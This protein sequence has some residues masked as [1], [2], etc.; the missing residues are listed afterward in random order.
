MKIKITADSTADL[1]PELYKAYDIDCLPLYLV[2]GGEPFKDGLE[3]TPDDI[4]AH[5]DGGGQI[6]STAAISVADYINYFT[7][8]LEEYD[9]IIHINIATG[10]SACHQNCNIAVQ[11]MGT[12]RI[13]PVDSH[14]LSL[15]SGILALMARHYAE[16]GLSPQE[17][18]AKLESDREKRVEFDFVLETLSYLH[19]GGRCSS[20]AALGANLLRLHPCIKVSTEMNVGKKYRGSMPKVWDQWIR[21]RMAEPDTIDPE[22]LLLVYT[23]DTMEDVDEAIALCKSLVPFRNVALTRAGC[24]VTSHSGPHTLG[25]AFLRK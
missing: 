11:E 23:S 13:F 22:W 14:N 12:D 21:D 19:K 2:K 20:V 16:Q 10:Y 24:T 1:T 3:I 6:P 8:L 9:A 18:V 15:G 25:M 17:I 5:V 7:P 4:Y